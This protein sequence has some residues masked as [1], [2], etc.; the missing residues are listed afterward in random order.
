LSLMHAENERN[1]VKLR[2]IA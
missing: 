2:S 1:L